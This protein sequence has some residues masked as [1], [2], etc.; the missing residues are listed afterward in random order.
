MENILISLADVTNAAQTMRRQ[1]ETLLQ[2]LME[3]KR[4]MNSLSANWQS[5]AAETIRARFNGMV[6]IFENYRDIV[7]SY[8]K[9]LDYTVSS[10]EATEN[11]IQQ[12]A[13]SFQ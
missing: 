4:I 11:S 12:G 9:F 7:E 13:S 10:Y 2:A 1:N 6:P 8:A 3:M 5:P